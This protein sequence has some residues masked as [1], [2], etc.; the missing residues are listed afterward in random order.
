[1]NPTNEGSYDINNNSI[2]DSIDLSNNLN[3]MH[4]NK[5]NTMQNNEYQ[6]T[7]FKML[8]D[9][10]EKLTRQMSNL[11]SVVVQKN[12]EP[13]GPIPIDQRTPFPLK[14]VDTTTPTSTSEF[15]Y[16]DSSD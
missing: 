12:K 8:T 9:E 13:V 3:S 7:Q 5:H 11:S 4:V 1:M 10:I 15:Y 6:N 2:H 16:D 14:R